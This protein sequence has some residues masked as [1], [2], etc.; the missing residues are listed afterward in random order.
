MGINE[1]FNINFNQDNEK[2]K[3]WRELVGEEIFRN[4]M[5]EMK[6]GPLLWDSVVTNDSGKILKIDGRTFT[7][8]KNK[9]KKL[10]D[11]KY[12]TWNNK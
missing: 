8:W 1:Q 2:K 7:E 10:D 9:N 4:K 12:D 6:I 11:P 3:S 5:I